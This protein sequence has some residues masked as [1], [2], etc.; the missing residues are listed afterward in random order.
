MLARTDPG[1]EMFEVFRKTICFRHGRVHQ[2]SLRGTRSQSAIMQNV[3]SSGKRHEKDL[4]AKQVSKTNGQIPAEG[5]ERLIHASGM[6]FPLS[7]GPETTLGRKDPVTGIF[8]DVDLTPVDAQRTVARRH[9]KIYRRGMKFFLAEE[10]GIMNA[11]FLNGARLET[12]IP[13]QIKSGDELRLGAVVLRFVPDS[14]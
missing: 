3:R 6:E 9:A 11:T 7:T 12:G 2:E 13:Q 14:Q 10:I 4:M 5:P 8:P 1:L